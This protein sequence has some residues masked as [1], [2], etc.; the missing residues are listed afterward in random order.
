[1]FHVQNAQ[2]AVYFL[3]RKFN[4]NAHDDLVGT[5]FG[6][7][8]R[9]RRREQ[10]GG[11]PY[12]TGK[13]WKTDHDPWRGISR[14]AF[15]IDYLKQYYA[16]DRATQTAADVE[17]KMMELNHYGPDDNPAYGWDVYVQ[18][19]SCYIQHK[20]A[21]P[22]PTDPDIKSPYEQD[23]ANGDGRHNHLPRLESFDN[24]NAI[25]IF[26]N[27]HSGSFNDTMISARREWES[28]WRRL[29]F[30]LAY[31]SQDVSNDDTLAL[32]CMK[33][34][35]QDVW[36]SVA[37]AWE[38]YLDACNTHVTILEDKIYEQPAD[39]S[40]APELWTNSSM[41]LKVERL[42]VI[43]MD[44]VKEC[45]NN[46]RELADE[47][48]ISDNWIE[49]SP[50][51]L[52]KLSNLIQEDLVK[53]IANL[54]DLM[55]KSVGIR[56]S[57]HGL[58]L[59][60][61]MWRLSWITF[62]FLPL[63]FIVGFFG[64][65]VDTFA[66]VPSVKWYFIAT[67]PLMVLV[68]VAWYMIKH[69]LERA[70][71]TPYSRGIYEHLFTQLATQYPQ[72]WTRTGPREY[73]RPQGWLARFKWSL[74]KRWSDPSRTIKSGPDDDDRF[75]GLGAWSRC[76]R[77][78]LRRWTS[79]INMLHATGATDILSEGDEDE[80]VSG[81]IGEVAEML[82]LPATAGS[83]DLE[84]GML[85]VPIGQQARVTNL[86]AMNR[87]E[88][89]DRPSSTGSSGS[90]RNSGVMVEEERPNW[91]REFGEKG[92][93]WSGAF[94]RASSERRREGERAASVL[95]SSHEDQPQAQVFENLKDEPNA[96]AR[97]RPVE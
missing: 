26:E 34:I 53:P 47:P 56:D 31:E 39:E 17:D 30:Y 48:T 83:P 96:D 81:G 92:Y 5:D 28:R 64:M 88:S 37:E 21:T 8:L 19:M 84:A 73:I 90:K 10:R 58:Q 12:L 46:L 23:S 44:I 18:R 94:R 27:S 86:I 36:K 91:L 71:Q 41:F 42:M 11:K 3:L 78:L 76:Q 75:D 24:G 29:P 2:W 35:L 4:I 72:L 16:K 55:Y 15:G 67:A 63:T 50:T 20:E 38:T 43:H 65:N 74:I 54:S 93:R 32:E 40:R 51:D 82:A 61:S 22:V 49:S 95:S 59:S 68:L 62:I 85:K 97:S 89:A 79:E 77:Y 14:T 80:L 25:L 52:D 6:K 9:H 70:R 1:M 7:Y 57:R 45:Q 66:D 33:M 87:L 69:Y 13:T 60:M